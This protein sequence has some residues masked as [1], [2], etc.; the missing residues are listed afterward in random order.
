[1][2]NDRWPNATGQMFLPQIKN[3]SRQHYSLSRGRYPSL[4]LPCGSAIREVPRVDRLWTCGTRYYPMDRVLFL[5]IPLGD[6]VY[7]L[8]LQTDRKT[9]RQTDSYTDRDRKS[10]V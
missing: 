9:H 2:S 7:L 1:M 3:P 10:V 4:G 5:H 6:E 8:C